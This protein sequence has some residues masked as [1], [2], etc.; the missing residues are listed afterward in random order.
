EISIPIAA[1]L[2][3]NTIANTAGATLAGMYAAK[4]LGSARVPIFSIF[5]TLGILFLSEIMPKT[6]GAVHWR[7]LWPF[8]VWPLT[9]MK[10]LLYPV[11]YITQF[12][13]NIITRGHK[14]VT[15]TEEE[16][17]AAARMGAKEGEISRQEHLIIDNLIN[18]EN[19]KVREVMTPRTVIFSLNANLTVREALN[20]ADEKG[21]T[22]VPIYEDDKENIMGYV[23]IHDL[24][25]AKN[26]EKPARQL[27]NIL[28]PISFIPESINCLTVLT[29]FL[30]RRKHIAI[31]SDEY[32]G[33]AGLVTLEDLLETLLGTEIVDET[34]RVV[35]LQKTARKKMTRHNEK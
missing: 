19:K 18:L 4:V 11:I 33:V 32:H 13:S 21:F 28:R 10:L 26:L 16:I 23:M 8:I 15:I 5:F 6:L 1:I 2:I 7:N 27:K 17:L 30:R 25:S 20:I 35:D 31:V 24:S 34:D 29:E 14:T 22:R 12:I 3:L 9:L